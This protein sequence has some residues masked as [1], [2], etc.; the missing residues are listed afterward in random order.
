MPLAQVRL[1]ARPP[2]LLDKEGNEDGLGE[3][4]WAVAYWQ[5]KI[6][7]ERLQGGCREPSLN[8]LA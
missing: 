8:G 4:P 7:K 3:G 5:L 1:E 2:R 6:P